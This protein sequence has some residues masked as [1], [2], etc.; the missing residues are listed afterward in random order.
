MA[1]VTATEFKAKCLDYLD[2]VNRGDLDELVVTKRGHAVA[3]LVAP[4]RSPL[5]MDEWRASMKDSVTIP[6]DVDLTA[7]VFN[8]PWDAELGITHR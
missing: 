3:R 8:E 4:Q 6:A 7:P 2:Q 5:S 1:S